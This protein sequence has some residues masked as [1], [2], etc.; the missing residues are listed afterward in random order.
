MLWNLCS[1]MNINQIDNDFERKSMPNSE[2]SPLAR[3]ADEFRQSSEEAA[4]QHKRDQAIDIVEK[5]ISEGEKCENRKGI[6]VMSHSHIGSGHQLLSMF[7]FENRSYA[8]LSGAEDSVYELLFRDTVTAEDI[9]DGIAA[10]T[11]VFELG[12]PTIFLGNIQKVLCGDKQ[13]FHDKLGI[14]F[15]LLLPDRFRNIFYPKWEEPSLRIHFVIP[16]GPVCN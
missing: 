15:A 9:W 12:K 6:S 13:E 14:A 5:I 4:L 8:V 7:D 10:D 11:F 16:C 1:V 2:V 3:I